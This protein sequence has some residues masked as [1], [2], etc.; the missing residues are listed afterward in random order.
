MITDFRS[1]YVLLWNESERLYAC[2]HAQTQLDLYLSSWLS[3]SQKTAV[4]E[5]KIRYSGTLLL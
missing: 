5:V 1:V 4:R 2:G 3:S